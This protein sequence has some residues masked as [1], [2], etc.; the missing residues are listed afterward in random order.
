MVIVEHKIEFFHRC[1][2]GVGFGF[3]EE[4]SVNAIP[5]IEEHRR[6]HHTYDDLGLGPCSVY[7]Y[8]R[9]T[10]DADQRW[11]G[12]VIDR[13]AANLKF[14]WNLVSRTTV[15][16]VYRGNDLYRFVQGEGGSCSLDYQG[17]GMCINCAMKY[18]P[19]DDEA[20]RAFWAKHIYGQ[21]CPSHPRRIEIP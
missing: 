10:S 17:T 5:N 20:R 12:S 19:G 6:L 4:Q 9:H 15:G 16:Y 3:T 18:T 8:C 11:A 14:R 21:S 2:C 13:P 7:S 1:T